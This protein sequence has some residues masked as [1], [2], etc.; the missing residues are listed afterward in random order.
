MLLKGFADSG[1]ED[2][3][4]EKDRYTYGIYAENEWLEYWG[5]SLDLEY[6]HFQWGINN[7]SKVENYAAIF[8]LSY[9]PDL[10]LGVTWEQ[11][12]DPAEPFEQWLGYNLSYQYSQH[13]QFNL[14]Y[15][16]RRGGNACTAGICYQILPFDGIE[17][18]LTS[19][20]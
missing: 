17:L 9:A 8:S 13:H 1:Q 6:Q 3:R 18:R 14:F 7:P 20:L 2:L 11:T 19:I 15:G 16:K 10:S 12:T 5:T 4:L